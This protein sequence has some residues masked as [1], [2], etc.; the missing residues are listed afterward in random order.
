MV[1]TICEQEIKNFSKQAV[2]AFSNVLENGAVAHAPFDISFQN[3][4][5]DGLANNVL[6]Q[7][8]FVQ[9]FKQLRK[10]EG[11]VLYWFEICSEVNNQNIID[12]LNLYKQK[13]PRRAIPH[14]K[15]SIETKCLYV[16]KVK[17]DFYGRVMQ[18]MGYHSAAATGGLQMHHW[19]GDIPLEI[20]VHAFEFLPEMTDFMIPLENHLA[21]VLKPL[22]GQHK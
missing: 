3:L 11:P 7:G 8:P 4:T 2:E 20:K 15:K 18:H 5:Y 10:I 22:I 16:G 21:S 13:V 6:D 12:A 17:R 19:I 9:M 1:K 14:F